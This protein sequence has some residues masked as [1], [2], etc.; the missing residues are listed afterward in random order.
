MGA[1][2]STEIGAKSAEVQEREKADREHEL[3]VKRILARNDTNAEL[4][5][6]LIESA[7]GKDALK[8]CTR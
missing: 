3:E 6:A 8:R 1:K 4:K 5:Q 7:E 2:N